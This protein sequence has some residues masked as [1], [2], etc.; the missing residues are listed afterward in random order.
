M[1]DGA[2]EEKKE[3]WL[4]FPLEAEGF[5]LRYQ[6]DEGC[7]IE[8]CFTVAKEK[9]A[10]LYKDAVKAVKKQVTIPGFRQGKAPENLIE[11]DYAKFIREE[12]SRIIQ[13]ESFDL[14]KKEFPREI[15]DQLEQVKVRFSEFNEDKDVQLSFFFIAAPEGVKDFDLSG[16]FANLPE[17]SPKDLD[18]ECEKELTGLSFQGTEFKLVEGR[19]HIEEGDLISV[20]IETLEETPSCIAESK[21]IHLLPI[22]DAPLTT[23]LL[24]KAIG[25]SVETESFLT[26]ED[27]AYFSSNPTLKNLVEKIKGDTPQKLKVTILSIET[28]SPRDLDDAFAK[29]VGVESLEILKEKIKE[30]NINEEKR[31]IESLK[32]T[33]LAQYLLEKYPINLPQKIELNEIRLKA[34]LLE[35]GFRELGLEPQFLE[36]YK[37]EI[38]QYLKQEVDLYIR[39]FYLLRPYMLE[40]N[41]TLPPQALEFALLKETYLVSPFEKVTTPDMPKEHATQRLM[42]KLFA[43]VSLDRLLK[44]LEPKE[45]PTEAPVE[46]KEQEENSSQA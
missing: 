26:E 31:S 20:K 17:K 24:G 40:Q 7:L 14:L 39:L 10:K 32:R 5:S 9:A 30:K 23:L 11:R 34:Y 37:E 4:D 25:D 43:E 19:Q 38:F 44:S 27:W 46:N 29:E 1:T 16:F 8:A 45:T 36:K 41:I 13:K 12:W 35:E 18:K 3:N 21:K 33:Q 2:V 28:G 22:L 15:L 6:E 42:M